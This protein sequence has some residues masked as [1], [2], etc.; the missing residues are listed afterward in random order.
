VGGRTKTDL[1]TIVRIIHSPNH[2][3]ANITPN[4]TISH[5]RENSA[6]ELDDSFPNSNPGILIVNDIVLS[7][8]GWDSPQPDRLYACNTP[9]QE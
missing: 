9:L 4:S 1:D 3:T 8:E 6:Q 5:S 2:P 7:F